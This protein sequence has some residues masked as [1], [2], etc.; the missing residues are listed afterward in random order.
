[1]EKYKYTQTWFLGS[2]IKYSVLNFID[3]SKKNTVLEIGCFEG[4]S[5]VYFA[6]NLLNNAESS[7]TC[8]D[9]FLNIDN[10]DH[11]QYLYHNEESN[12][13]YNVSICNNSE[14]I[15]INKIISDEFFKKNKKTFNFIYIDGS[16]E[17]EFITRDMENSFSVLENDG[18]MWMDDYGQPQIKKTMDIFLEKYKGLYNIIHIGYQLAI[19][20]NKTNS[21]TIKIIN[22]KRREDRKEFMKNQLINNNITNYEFI[23]AVDGSTLNPTIEI[24]ELFLGNDFNYRKGV[25]GCAL[26]HYNLWKQLINDTN[27]EYY[28]I[29][30]D[31]AT[32]CENFNK[33]YENIMEEYKDEVLKDKDIIFF[34]YHMYENHRESVR[35]IYENNNENII[36][37][38]LNKNL[39]MGGT[40]MYLITKE[41]A[42]KM[43]DYI[44]IN[45]IKYAIDNVLIKANLDYYYESQP[46]LSTA[47][48]YDGG[49]MIDTDIQRNYDC[50]IFDNVYDKNYIYINSFWNGFIDKTDP[51]NIEFLTNILKH[52]KKINN[53]EI[54]SDINKANV[55]IESI[56]GNSLVAFKDWKYKIHYSGEPFSNKT[57]DY[58][59]VLDSRKTENNIVDLPVCVYYIN[60]FNLF[61]KIN[62]RSHISNVPTN[63][64]CFIVSNGNCQIRNTFFEIL[65]KYKKVDSYGR[66]MNN[67]NGNIKYNWWSEEYINVI[68]KYKFIIC[69]ENSKFG[70]YTT[71]KLV[72]PYL[73]KV[74][75][76]YWGTHHVKNIFNPKSMLF[77]EDESIESCSN[78]IERIIE[79]DNNDNKYLEFI[80]RPIFDNL[81]YW[82]NHYNVESIAKG[83][84]DIIL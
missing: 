46:H 27:N 42:R 80:N 14:K 26:S 28:L 13:D 60:S 11:K 64:C 48:W 53:F 7:L 47:V 31:D 82:N 9:P 79:L 84:D 23:E 57:S 37:T 5:S 62:N 12:F 74:I 71:E 49:R 76:I 58:D 33:K 10:N 43:I 41:G 32:L 75:P 15:N 56:F 81:E 4:L 20:K 70:T 83:I 17:C 19:R 1:M 44:S 38:P 54:E 50:M 52:T 6:D 2:E 73:A 16:H 72:N 18:V 39:Y 22:L 77:L 61:E 24:K 63:F 45:G 59:I 65:N 3:K 8:V 55:L 66:Y 67:T 35:N 69:F 30:E 40:H 51:N 78:L 34:G 36:L 68:S 25:I 29:I 21:N